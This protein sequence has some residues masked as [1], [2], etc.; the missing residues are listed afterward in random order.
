MQHFTRKDGQLIN[1]KFMKPVFLFIFFTFSFSCFSQS[2]EDNIISEFQGKEKYFSMN[3]FSMAEPQFAL[4]PSFGARISERSEFFAEAAYVAKSPFYN[5]SWN[6]VEKLTG[7]RVIIQYRYHFLQQW[8]PWFNFRK[9]S[10]LL[11]SRHQPF[12]GFEFRI[13]PV[14]FST[15][16]SFVNKT[17]QDTLFN[18]P[19]NANAFTFGGALIFGNTFNLSSD[20]KWKLEVTFGIGAKHK[21]V[22][23]KTVPQNYIPFYNDRIAFQVPLLYEEI[24][25]AIFPCAIRI[26]YILQ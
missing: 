1:T 4:G 15:K 3:F 18:Y 8:K 22:N 16:G 7:A 12:I 17:I 11:R 9:K 21:L 10:K 23:F 2:I 13:K 20:N 24:G 25:S 6:D 19:F 5:N 26:R 14:S